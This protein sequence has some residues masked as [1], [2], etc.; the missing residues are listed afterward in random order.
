VTRA[1]EKVNPMKEI[2]LAVLAS[3]AS[4]LPAMAADVSPSYIRPPPAWSWTGL[5]VG[6]NAGWAGSTDAVTNLGTDT[7]GGGLGTSLLNGGIPGAINLNQTG[8]IGGGQV[9]YNWQVAP[10]WVVGIE[11]DFGGTNAKGS[12]AFT[13]LGN[14]GF[15]PI[16]TTYSRELDWLGTLRGRFGYLWFPSLLLY[17][18][19]GL[20]YGEN[21]IGAAAVCSAWAPPC[22]SEGGTANQTSNT[23]VGWTLGTGAEWRFAPA[24]SVRAEYLYVEFG[25]HS[26]TISYAYAGNVSTL[27]SSVRERDNIVR[28]GVNY[29]FGY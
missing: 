13:F 14:P 8:F 11:A 23:S 19:G 28:F 15:P 3:C 16:T 7:G 26:S 6:A 17:G 4:I 2:L 29:M 9:G 5:Y 1:K 24:W 10:T 22:Q 18:T 21:K 12:N 25:R 27:T 20:A